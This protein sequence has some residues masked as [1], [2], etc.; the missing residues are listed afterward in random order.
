MP[1]YGN[2]IR[3]ALVVALPRSIQSRHMASGEIAE[4]H[5]GA[6]RE[7]GLIADA[8]F[9]VDRIVPGSVEAGDRRL[10]LVDDLGTGVGDEAA[11]GEHARMQLDAVEWR[12]AQRTESGAG[13]FFVVARRLPDV[14]LG[15]TPGRF[16]AMK[17]L[18]HALAGECVEALDSG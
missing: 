8:I 17:I 1:G 6:E 5:A 15:E 9:R 14:F 3:G 13:I 2:V 10:P 12:D 7:A 11:G 16:A 4:G 18:V